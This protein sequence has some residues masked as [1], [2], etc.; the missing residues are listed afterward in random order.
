[1]EKWKDVLILLCPIF[2][3]IGLFQIVVW[4]VN[5]DEKILPGEWVE[6]RNPDSSEC[7][8]LLQSERWL[9]EKVEDEH[10]FLVGSCG[11]RK[12]IHSIYIRKAEVRRAHM[13]IP[14]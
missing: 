14:I 4:F 10:V 3:I 2:G 11:Q 1:M 9:V 13:P 5:R 7:L 8:S 6:A 12:K